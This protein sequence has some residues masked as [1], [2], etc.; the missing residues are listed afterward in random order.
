MFDSVRR[1][2]LDFTRQLEGYVPFMYVDVKNLVT[3]GAGNLIDA[4]GHPGDPAAPALLLPWKHPDG[5]PA[6]PEEIRAAWHTVKNA[7]AS[8]WSTARQGA[9]TTLRLQDADIQ[10][11]VTKKLNDFEAVIKNRIAPWETLPADAQLA[12][13]S[14]AWAMGPLFNYPRLIAALNQ[15]VPDFIAAAKQA[16]IPDLANP[17]LAPRNKANA[18]LFSN[19]ENTLKA[20]LPLGDLQFDVEDFA[21]KVFGRLRSAGEAAGT[22]VAQN[23][24]STEATAFAAA[25]LAVGGWY[26]WSHRKG[27]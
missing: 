25:A 5:G 13:L 22:L 17:G 7:G 27:L 16:Y 10:A 23:P 6:S 2:F 8:E 24:K 9:L 1:A 3:T 12:V 21:K 26:V 15:P 18:E 11:L 20:G 4:S 14:M 19:A